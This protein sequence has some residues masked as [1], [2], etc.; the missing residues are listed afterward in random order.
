MRLEDY[1]KRF[2]TANV[3]YQS[4]TDE[5]SRAKLLEAL[6]R[7]FNDV[8]YYG[9]DYS[10]GVLVVLYGEQFA[11]AEFGKSLDEVFADMLGSTQ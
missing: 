11:Q 1:L 3:L 9:I 6:E 8:D 2:K 10:F 7:S 5:A 4:N